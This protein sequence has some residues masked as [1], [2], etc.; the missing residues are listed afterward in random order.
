MRILFWRRPAPAEERPSRPRR[1]AWLGGHRVLTT[2]PYVLPKDKAEGDRLDLQ[3]YLVRHVAQ[4]NYRAPVR[5][6]RTILDVATGTGIWAREIAQQFPLARV[7]GF[8]IDRTPLE[9]SL[10]VLGPSGQFPENFSFQ[11]ADALQPFPFADQEFDFVHARFISPFVPIPA[12]PQVVG[13]MMRILAPGGIIEI[14]ELETPPTS[15][16]PAYNALADAG[17]KLM[18]GR[19]LY[20]GVGND[21][22]G[23][24][25]RAGAQQVQQRRFVIGTGDQ[26]QRQQRMLAS[27]LLAA[28][29]HSKVFTVR[30]GLL[31]EDQYDALLRQARQEVAQVGITMPVVF[32]F[33]KKL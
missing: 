6:P 13:E 8:D 9:R 4:G 24:L 14:V 33:G 15:A 21:L 16:S 12:W 22:V 7:I 1:W 25:H 18:E 20:R 23:Y 28:M 10:E 26:A 3:H 29:E 30:A 17:S 27:D 2:T 5:S 31:P 32:C 11:L 19:N